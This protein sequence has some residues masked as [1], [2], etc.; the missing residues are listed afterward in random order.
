L[1]NLTALTAI[2]LANAL[3][4]IVAYPLILSRVGAESY[5][6]IVVAES[7]TLIMLA[8]IT[9]SF[10]VEGVSRIA[11]A[12][13]AGHHDEASRA[14]SEILFVRLL[15][16]AACLALVVLAMPLLD[17]PAR[18]ILLEWLMFP[19]AYV[20]QAAWFFQGLE[21]NVVPAVV[22]ITSRV[23]CLFL[24]KSF[25]R[26]PA[27][28]ILAP[29][30]IGASYLAGGITLCFYAILRYRLRIRPPSRKTIAALAWNGKEIFFGNV[31]VVLYRDSNVL[32]LNAISSSSVVAVYSIAEK[33][34]KVFQA[35][36]R[37]LNQF[38]FPKI[39]RA[40]SGEREPSRPVF[41][42]IIRYTLPQLAALGAGCVVIAVSFLFFRDLFPAPLRS[43]E[44]RSIFHLIG[45]MLPA[46]FFG[47]ANFMLGTG[48]LNY[49]GRRA[50]LARSILLTGVCSVACCL[51]LV[52]LFNATG[53]S[54]SFV[55][56]EVI[57]FGQIARIYRVDRTHKPGAEMRFDSD[58]VKAEQA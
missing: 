43:G 26:Q 47:V 33:A 54:I 1:V 51:L 52:R 36:A 3:L 13:P 7:V 41:W 19:L 24:I 22:V 29:L 14:Y 48:G 2:Q 20:F 38:F 44:A 11:A 46:V 6:K 21:R 4:P 30:I 18:W 55:L 35:G 45:V 31:S 5:S 17:R 28:F 34:I 10:D 50:P 40:I 42:K 58:Q 32:I 12:D 23:A 39:I 37:P 9:F 56:A 49:L 8:V 53:A 25:V 15:V 27:D 16:F 57:L